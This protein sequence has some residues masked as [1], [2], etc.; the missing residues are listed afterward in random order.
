[1]GITGVVLDMNYGGQLPND[2]AMNS[3]RLLAEKVVPRFK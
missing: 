2:K 3:L 1:M